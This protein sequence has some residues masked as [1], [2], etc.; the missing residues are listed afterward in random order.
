MFEEEELLPIS[1][2]QHLVFCERQWALIHLERLWEENVLTTEGKHLHNRVDSAETEV[3]GS[4]RIA[5]GLPLR[6]LRLG[7]SGK[8]DVVEFRQVSEAS[9]TECAG[10]SLND[11][12][13]LWQPNPVEYKRGKPKRDF[14]DKVQIC[15][16]AFC[17]EE[18]IKA[19]VPSGVLYYG[20]SRKRHEVLFDNELRHKTEAL[21]SHLHELTKKG[22]TPIAKYGKKCKSCSLLNLCMPKTLGRKKVE[23]YLASVISE[24]TESE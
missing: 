21:C 6:S 9:N 24:N 19:Y 22:K 5:R 1:A 8:A 11:A 2:L 3:R 23:R 14:S 18:M 15:A 7:L 10:V 17:I 20:T 13:G 12:A 16:Q 4:I